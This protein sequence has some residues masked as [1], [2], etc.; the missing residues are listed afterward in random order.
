MTPGDAR[1][2]HA[3]QP[4]FVLSL[5]CPFCSTSLELDAVIGAQRQDCESC[6]RPF[7]VALSAPTVSTN[8]IK[9]EP[10]LGDIATRE[11]IVGLKPIGSSPREG[12]RITQVAPAAHHVPYAD[13]ADV[14][15]DKHLRVTEAQAAAG[16]P[17][18]RPSPTAKDS[19]RRLP[20]EPPRPPPSRRAPSSFLE[21]AAQPAPGMTLGGLQLLARIG[22]GGMGTVWLARQIS[23]DRNVAVKILRP[24]LGDD[25]AFVIQFTREAL[26]AAQLVHHNIAQIYDIGLEDRL[27]YFSMEYVEGESLTALLKREGRLDPEVAAGYL[28]QAARGLEFAH[29]R[30]MIHRDI[31]PENLL[32]NLDG[33]VKVADLGLVK[34]LGERERPVSAPSATVADLFGAGDVVIGTPAYMAPEQVLNATAVDAR[35]DIYSLGCTLYELLTG[36]PPFEGASAEQV[37]SLHISQKPVP[38]SERNHRVPAEL[39][40]L[41]LKMMERRP[42]DRFQDMGEVVVA[43]EHFLGIDGAAIFSPREEHAALLERSVL[44]FEDA[45]WARRRRVGRLV[46]FA[47]S[48]AMVVGSAVLGFPAFAAWACLFIGTSTVTSFFINS[49]AQRAPVLLKLRHLLLGAPLRNW[50][51]A[52]VL[53]GIVAGVLGWNGLLVGVAENLGLAA[54]VGLASFLLLDR[55]VTRQR[56]PF[57]KAVEE[58]LKSMRLKGL[59]EQQLRQFVCR[60]SGDTWEEFYEALFGYDAK[61]DARARWAADE[62]GVPRKRF[63]AWRDPL[64]RLIERRLELRQARREAKQLANAGKKARL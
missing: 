54:V 36:K 59:E 11:T 50:A 43:L 9:L 22:G 45:K 20:I 14:D 31:K 44:A 57:V 24:H 25:P 38:P 46:F 1:V 29:E 39:S 42:D 48:A 51:I 10:A 17:S 32:L 30:G 6:G 27:H 62:K 47:L 19:K 8:P 2:W 28:L 3:S 41:T 5:A 40:D 18:R 53:L 23:L 55:R 52:F 15:T 4:P 26:A 56:K 58:M 49:F 12:E 34:H 37:L 21:P 61:L 16:P 64:V 7:Y 35:A 33:I 60:Y 63:G 13:V